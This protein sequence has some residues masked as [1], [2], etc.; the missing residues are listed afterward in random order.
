[1]KDQRAREAGRQCDGD[2]VAGKVRSVIEK[3]ERAYCRGIPAGDKAGRELGEACDRHRNRRMEKRVSGNVQLDRRM[4]E[5]SSW[6]QL[7]RQR[8][9]KVDRGAPRFQQRASIFPVRARRDELSYYV[10]ISANLSHPRTRHT[11][12]EPA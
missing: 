10:V 9:S 3:K 6:A 12:L 5:V 8:L 7:P 1:M 2:T 11:N 4:P